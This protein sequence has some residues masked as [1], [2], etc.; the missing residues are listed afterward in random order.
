MFDTA[1]MVFGFKDGELQEITQYMAVGVMEKDGERLLSF[2]WMSDFGGSYS[3][4][5]VR[6]GAAEYVS[7]M[8][9]VAD[10]HGGTPHGEISIDGVEMSMEEYWAALEAIPTMRLMEMWHP[11]NVEVSEVFEVYASRRFTRWEAMHIFWDYAN[12]ISALPVRVRYVAEER[13]EWAA[14]LGL[15]VVDLNAFETYHERVVYGYGYEESGLRIIFTADEPVRDFRLIN[16][17]WDFGDDGLVYWA[18]DT[19]FELD[20][21]VSDKPLVSAWQLRGG[22]G[23]YRGF[24]FVD[25]NDR[26]RYFSI[27]PHGRDGSIV[28][29]E[30]TPWVEDTSEWFVPVL[31]AY[32]GFRYALHDFSGN[33]VYTLFIR[34]IGLTWIYTLQDGVPASVVQGNLGDN[35]GLVEDYAGNAVIVNM[36]GRNSWWPTD[37]YTIDEFGELVSVAHFFRSVGW[38]DETGLDWSVTNYS[39][40]VDGEWQG[41]TW[42]SITEEEYEYYLQRYGVGREIELEW[43]PVM[44][45]E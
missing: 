18:G 15:A 40:H 3:F 33:G 44:A 28:L 12:E 5:R 16:V 25:E 6:D 7:T 22:L 10:W 31:N 34:G 26:M 1:N 32:D 27:S 45:G 4:Y 23:I 19:V 13:N 38:D 42:I 2:G 43:R 11:G 8:R 17:G 30:F 36:W 20:Y 21:L 39:K 35:W 9:F 29:N 37:F 14:R 41:G 24:S